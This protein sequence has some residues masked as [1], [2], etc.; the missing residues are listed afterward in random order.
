MRLNL[1]TVI[2]TTEEVVS[3]VTKLIADFHT[4]LQ[5][6]G[7]G[8]TSSILTKDNGQ[9]DVTPKPPEPVVE[10]PAPVEEPVVPTASQPVPVE[11]PAE[12]PVEPP[13]EAP[14][15]PP[16]EPGPAPS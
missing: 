10:E 5:K 8:V 11:P 16:V 9:T 15:E 12:P 4:E 13:A 3:E 6:L 14:V 2:E 7:L 1:H